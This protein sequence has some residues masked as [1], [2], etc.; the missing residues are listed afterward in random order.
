MFGWWRQKE[1]EP[2]SV[3]ANRVWEAEGEVFVDVRGQTCPGYLLA[4]NHAV[5]PLAP[6]TPVCLQIT[7]PPCADDV[8]AWAASRGHQLLGMDSTD[9]LFEIRLIRG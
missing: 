7:Y 5:D 4:I 1:A 2:K 8:R 9:T 6:G 3:R